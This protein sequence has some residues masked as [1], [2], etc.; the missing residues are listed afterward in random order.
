M[1]QDAL[2]RAPITADET[3]LLHALADCRFH[4]GAADRRFILHMSA[5]AKLTMGMGLT[6]GQRTYLWRLGYRYRHQLP[7]AVSELV[8]LHGSSGPTA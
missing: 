4:P 3:R 1:T 7:P 8:A 2:P 6:E 5:A